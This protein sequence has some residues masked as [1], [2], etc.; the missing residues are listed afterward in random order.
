MLSRVVRLGGWG[1]WPLVVY[2]RAALL[3]GYG[4]AYLAALSAELV[5]GGDLVDHQMRLNEERYRDEC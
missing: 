1:L 3:V 4:M 2:V 5:L